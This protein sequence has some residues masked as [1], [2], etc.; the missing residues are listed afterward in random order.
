MSNLYR[1]GDDMG[2]SQ[3]KKEWSRTWRPLSIIRRKYYVDEQSQLYR[4][5]EK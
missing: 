2:Y 3:L 4:K 1:V 5:V